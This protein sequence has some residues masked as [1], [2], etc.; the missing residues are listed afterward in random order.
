MQPLGCGDGARVPP[1]QAMSFVPAQPAL[2]LDDYLLSGV[3]SAKR[4]A[5]QL[6]KPFVASLAVHAVAAALL[7]WLVT[8]GGASRV[9][10]SHSLIQATLTAPAQKFVVPDPPVQPAPAAHAVG[11]LPGPQPSLLPVPLKPA[12][13]RSPPKGASEGR[14]TIDALDASHAVEPALEALLQQL[15]PQAVRAAPDFEVPPPSIYPKAAL[16]DKRQLNL[17]VLV[18]IHEDGRVGLLEGSFADPMFGPSIDASL[19]SARA[20]PYQV[21]GK[22]RTSWSLMSFAFEFVGAP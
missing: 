14:V 2:T 17:V 20:R 4:R 8:G 22:A 13:T 6:A 3:R 7:A 11:P 12:P 19:A 10:G 5:R 16:P 18:V 1:S 15:H 21:D 9:A